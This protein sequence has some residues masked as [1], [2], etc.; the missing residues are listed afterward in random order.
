MSKQAKSRYDDK[1]TARKSAKT[2]YNHRL[3]TTTAAKTTYNNGIGTTKVVAVVSKA[4]DM[5]KTTLT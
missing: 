4:V 2:R 3:G 1:I 5:K